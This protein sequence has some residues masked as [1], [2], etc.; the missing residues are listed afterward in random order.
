MKTTSL[1]RGTVRQ[2]RSGVEGS[3]VKNVL[4]VDVGG[5]SVR[6]CHRQ[7][8]VDQAV[9]QP[10][11]KRMVP[12]LSS[13]GIGPMT[14]CRSAIPARSSR[15]AGCRTYNLGS[16][17]VGFDFAAAFGC[18]VKIV[19]DAQYGIGKLPGR[20]VLFRVSELDSGQP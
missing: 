9:G 2:D 4:V 19:N 10:H 7:S 1:G 3:S 12:K 15:P 16:G 8:D 14:G 11:P 18:P 13:H 17:W 5:T 20:R 6:S